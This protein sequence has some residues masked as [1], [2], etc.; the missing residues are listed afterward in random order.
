M[1]RHEVI[2]N[3]ILLPEV[4]KLISEGYS[5]TL[6]VKGVSMSPFMVHLRDKAV[7][8]P[9]EKSA[10]NVGDCILAKVEGGN[11]VLHRII[12]REGDNLTLK[13]DGNIA[14]CE[15]CTINDVLGLMTAVIRK[16]RTVSMS[17]FRW[18]AYSRIWMF[19][20][21]VRRWLLAIWRRF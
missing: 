10:L 13:G 16:G 5:V 20:D 3:G 12:R 17:S 7:I 8:G 21:P 2:D 15:R 6:T 1:K 9:F 19:L 11:F 4:Q 14:G 18:K